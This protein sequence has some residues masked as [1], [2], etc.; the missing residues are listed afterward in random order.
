M[1]SPFKSTAT[2]NCLSHFSRETL[3]FVSLGPQIPLKASPLPRRSRVT[4]RCPWWTRFLLSWMSFTITTPCRAREDL[5]QSACS[6]QHRTPCPLR[7]LCIS[8]L[9]YHCFRSL[10][11]P[12]KA[13]RLLPH[14][15]HPCSKAA[16]QLQLSQMA[17]WHRYGLLWM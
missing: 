13:S 4:P 7:S 1:Y 11:S 3:N 9:L 6:Q 2:F 15:L 8:T 17:T 5:C 12:L 16:R 14:H 10:L